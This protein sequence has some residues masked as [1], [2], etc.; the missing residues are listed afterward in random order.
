VT[1][2]GGACGGCFYQLPPQRAAEVRRGETLVVCEGC[3]RM[4]VAVE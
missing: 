1:L 4:I 3:G 2:N